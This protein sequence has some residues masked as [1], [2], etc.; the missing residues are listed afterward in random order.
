MNSQSF[1]FSEKKNDR[2][3]RHILFWSVWTP[4]FML[5]HIASPILKPE[6][7]NFNNIP[8]TSAESFMIVAFQVPITYITLYLILPVY[9]RQNKLLKAVVLLVAAWCAHY[10]LYRYVFINLVPVILNATIPGKY[11]QDTQ[12]PESVRHFMAILAVFLGAMT[13]TTFLAGFK[14][15]KQWYL[16]EQKNIQLQKENAESQL[17]LL[18]AQVHPHFLF[19]TLNNIYS[20]T[21][22][23]SPRG[24]KMIMELSDVL[25]YIL[26]EGSKDLVPVQ[27]EL[28]MIRE[29]INLEKIRYGNKLDLHLSLPDDS[30]HLK[31]APLLLLPFVENCFKHGASRFLSGPWINLK[32]EIIDRELY[33]KLMNGKAPD[34][35]VL[36]PRSGTGIDNVRKRLELLYPGK[37]ELEIVDESEVFVVNLRLELASDTSSITITELE[38][39]TEYA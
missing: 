30:C 22:T 34:Q 39:K 26:A 20:Q 10:F 21:Q 17:Q 35:P 13:P 32:I 12:R 14:Y 31:I 19:N 11:L 2:I 8:F 15:I 3:W 6:A 5:L 7:S 29:Y 27:K 25:R 28:A 23:E 4:Y 36:H 24:S 9:T 37:H 33:M 38:P 1:I 16:K 18:T